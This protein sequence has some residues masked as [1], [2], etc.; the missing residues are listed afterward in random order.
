MTEP[1]NKIDENKVDELKKEFDDVVKI[2]DE[3]NKT[4]NIE[5]PILNES[6]TEPILNKNGEPVAKNPEEYLA[7]IKEILRIYSGGDSQ[8]QARTLEMI[9]KEF[10]Q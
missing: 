1:N 2:I 3:L 4:K 5:N 7:R 6:K 10:P 9:S 8:Q